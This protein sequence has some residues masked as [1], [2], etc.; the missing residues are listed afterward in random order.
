MFCPGSAMATMTISRAWEH[1]LASTTSSA[2]KGASGQEKC[3]NGCVIFHL[4][5]FPNSHLNHCL[6]RSLDAHG[7]AVSIEF[8]TVHCILDGLDGGLAGRQTSSQGWI[9][10][11]QLD[12]SLFR[13]RR[14]RERIG[15]LTNRVHCVLGVFGCFN[16]SPF[17]V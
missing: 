9:T 5:S 2:V 16:W 4:F 17:V 3:W 8:V 15:D 11:V 1:P 6:P 10:K 12:G 7:R 14:D 13:V